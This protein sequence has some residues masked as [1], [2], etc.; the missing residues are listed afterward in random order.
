MARICPVGRAH[1]LQDG[2]APDLLLDEHA[3]DAPH[4][5]AAEHDHDEADQ[6]QVVLGAE[7]VL[8]DVVLGRSVRPR[9]DEAVA[10]VRGE[11]AGQRSTASLAH[12]QQILVAGAAAEGEQAGCAQVVVVDQDPRAEAERADAAARLLAITPRI[13]NGCRRSPMLARPRLP[14]CG[15]APAGPAR[16]APAQ[17]VRVG[18][19]ALQ[20][21]RP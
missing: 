14:S 1:A 11:L 5:D 16:R 4:A 7:Q 12:A 3:R 15:A 6:A 9:L 8:A 20:H 21:Q 2:D 19:A 17:L 13:V 18:P 10:E